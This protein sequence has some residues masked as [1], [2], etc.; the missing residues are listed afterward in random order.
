VH[1]IQQIQ[2]DKAEASDFVIFP[3][4]WFLGGTEFGPYGK[5]HMTEM[6]RRLPTVPFPVV[7][8]PMW[9]TALNEARRQIV[10][11]FLTQNGIPDAEQR[12]LIAY[13]TAEGLY[14][15]EAEI[16]YRNMIRNYRFQS[17]L[18]VYGGGYRGFGQGYFGGGYYGGGF[19]G[20]GVGFGGW[21]Y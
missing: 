9:D 18:G 19:G 14:G 5:Y 15:E 1:N 17:Y 12:V 20:P 13:P 21:G 8:Q 10:V 6:V 2:A 7:I 4:E 3:N 16:V 11:A